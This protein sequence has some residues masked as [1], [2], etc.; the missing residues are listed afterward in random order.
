MDLLLGLGASHWAWRV[1]APS[2]SKRS[3]AEPSVEMVLMAQLAPY[4]SRS[5]LA[6]V[7]SRV[8]CKPWRHLQPTRARGSAECLETD[9]DA[10]VCSPISFSS[11]PVCKAGACER[12]R[13]PA[14]QVAR[15]R[16]YASGYRSHPQFHLCRTDRL[17]V[18]RVGRIRACPGWS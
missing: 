11:F 7:R 5:D 18:A 16:Y 3:V 17:S 6:D 13:A 10:L 2:V 1:R 9:S 15:L 8:G 12:N 14:D 4:I